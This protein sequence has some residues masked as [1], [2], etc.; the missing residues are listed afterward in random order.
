MAEGVAFSDQYLFANYRVASSQRRCI[1]RDFHLSVHISEQLSFG[2]DQMGSENRGCTYHV[3]YY[4]LV[5]TIP[6]IHTHSTHIVH[7]M[8]H[9]GWA[10]RM[11]SAMQFMTLLITSFFHAWL[12]VSCGEV[13]PC[14]RSD[15]CCSLTCLQL[16]NNCLHCEC[17]FKL[18]FSSLFFLQKEFEVFSIDMLATC[19]K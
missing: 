1:A 3:Y 11:S 16:N 2:V 18:A 7:H 12:W 5:N 10:T 19:P 9:N 6:C 15:G 4:Y 14:G 13:T 8:H 17:S